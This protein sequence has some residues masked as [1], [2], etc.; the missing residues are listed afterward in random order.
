M[1]N[2]QFLE[3]EFQLKSDFNIQLKPVAYVKNSRNEITDDYWGV[4]ISEITLTEEFSEDALKGLEEFSHIEILFYFHKASDSE[5][6][7]SGHPRGNP[8]W[9]ET[10][11]F[12]MRRKDRPNHFGLT[13]SKILKC[14]GKTI[15]VM[16]LDAI[17]GTPIIDIKPVLREFLPR[18]EVKQP[19]WAGELMKDYWKKS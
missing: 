17:N 8:D 4:I 9:P 19:A 3:S 12:A 11:I 16:G 5:I 18:E 7:F 15:L 2:E 14:E 1:H 6:V 13:I 10:G